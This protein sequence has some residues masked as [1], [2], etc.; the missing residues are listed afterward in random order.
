MLFENCNSKVGKCVFFF[1]WSYNCLNVSNRC[2]FKSCIRKVV[3]DVSSQEPRSNV[4]SFLQSHLLSYSEETFLRAFRMGDASQQNAFSTQ[5]LTVF[6]N[7]IQVRRSKNSAETKG[8]NYYTKIHDRVVVFF[9][10]IMLIWYFLKEE[11]DCLSFPWF[12]QL[13]RSA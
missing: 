8:K 1:F 10:V 9:V 5:E 12:I 11:N 13:Y 3:K 4:I 2:I 7:N 6:E